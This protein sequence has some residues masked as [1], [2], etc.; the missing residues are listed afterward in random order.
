MKSVLGRIITLVFMVL[1]ELALG[2]LL[3][4]YL[5]SKFVFIEVFLHILAVIVVLNIIRTS[6]HL[7]SDITWIFLIILFPVPATFVFLL[8]YFNLFINRTFKSIV[9]EEKKAVTFLNQDDEV[10]EDLKKEFPTYYQDFMFLKNSNFPIYY[11]NNF[12]YYSPGE[13]GFPVLLSELKKAKKYIF[14]EYFIIEEGIMFNSILDILKEKVKE[15][16]ECRVMYD[17]MGSLHT[18]P[19]SYANILESYGI[20]AVTFNKVTPILSTIM[21]NRDHRKILIIDGKVAFSGG[22]NLADEYINKKVVHGK[23]LDNIIRIKGKAVDSM[24]VT[25]LTNW[26]ALRHEDED[27]RNFMVEHREKVKDGF[28]VPYSET[29]LDFELTAQSVYMDILNRAQD[30]VYIMTPYL[31]IDEE[32]INCL[33]HTAKKGVDVK[34]IVPGV[35]D[36]KIIH[37]IGESYYDQLIKGG[38]KI[39]EYRPG[40]VHAKVFVSDD[41]SSVVGTINLDYRSLYLHFENAVLLYK[42]KKIM[43]I[44]KDFLN[45]LEDSVEIKHARF[46]LVKNFL[47]S[48]LRIFASLL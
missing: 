11:N 16:V 31:I 40:F 9:K 41:I 20:K 7:S 12:D 35:A 25:F 27:Y 44:K 21:N 6:K 1:G 45:A 32:M 33:I 47:M 42:S 13:K 10:L 24:L 5:T 23:W 36:K 17:D 28:I 39:Y 48:V 37:D 26:N 43:D 8:T 15:G 29:P 30:Y 19:K 4:N 2:V 14:M 22:V 46:S 18:L 34:I 3:F 38:V